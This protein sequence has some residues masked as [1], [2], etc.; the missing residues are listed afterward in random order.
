MDCYCSE[1]NTLKTEV[2]D[3]RKKKVKS[4]GVIRENLQGRRKNISSQNSPR[5]RPRL[6]NRNSTRMKDGLKFIYNV[7]KKTQFL[8]HRK[9]GIL[10]LERTADKYNRPL[11]QTVWINCKVFNAKS[12]GTSDNY[13]QLKV[14]V[15]F[16]FAQ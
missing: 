14:I 11:K 16:V 8:L 7:Y 3:K 4:N 9:N 6:S 2:R 10:S 13:Q 5:F 1:V 12:L 15:K